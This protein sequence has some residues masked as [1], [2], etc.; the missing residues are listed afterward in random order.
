MVTKNTKYEYVKSRKEYRIRIT[1]E[2]GKR[3]PIYG[4]TVKE[5]EAKLEK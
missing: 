3:I 5:L 4:K 2:F 1:D